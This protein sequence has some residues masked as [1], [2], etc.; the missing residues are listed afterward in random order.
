[1]G[2]TIPH[3]KLKTNMKPLL[4]IL[5]VFLYGV[6]S[7]QETVST[8]TVVV[9]KNTPVTTWVTYLE[10]ENLKI[11]YTLMDCFP[12]SGLDFQN[13]MLRF[14]NLTGAQLDLTWH[15]DLDFDGSCKTCSSDEYDR[16]LTL[17]ANEVQ[18]GNCDTKTGMTLDLFSKFIDPA[19][20]KGAELTAFKLADLTIQ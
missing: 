2:T 18:E 19:Y 15:L 6:A 12:N 13:V 4:T 1:M 17:Q 16:S 7:A 9:S 14:T 5:L 3:T 11:E 10:T 20:T 8:S